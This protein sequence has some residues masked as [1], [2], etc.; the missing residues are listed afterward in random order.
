MAGH[1]LESLPQILTFVCG[2]CMMESGQGKVTS[3]LLRE[4]CFF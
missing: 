1:H 3:R 4:L 2:A